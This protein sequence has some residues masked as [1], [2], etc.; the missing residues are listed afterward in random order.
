MLERLASHKLQQEHDLLTLDGRRH[1]EAFRRREPVLAY[2]APHNHL[3]SYLGMTGVSLS[4]IR[5]PAL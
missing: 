5:R 1:C 2:R 3:A 4:R